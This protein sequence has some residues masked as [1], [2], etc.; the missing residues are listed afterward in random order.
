MRANLQYAEEVATEHVR[1]LL[2]WRIIDGLHQALLMGSHSLITGVIAKETVSAAE[3]DKL[4]TWA[5]VSDAIAR[6]VTLELALRRSRDRAKI[7]TSVRLLAERFCGQGDNERYDPFAMLSAAFVMVDGELGKARVLVSKPPF[8]RRLAAFAQAALITRCVLSTKGDLSKF[9]AWAQSVR[10]AEYC[11]QGYVDLRSEPRWLADFAM[12][13]QLKDEIGGRVLLA[14]ASDEKATD[15]LGLRD[16]L[17]GDAPQ[18]LKKQL[19]LLF[20]LLPGP[21]EGNIDSVTQLQ[22]DVLEQMRK[23]LTDP[24]PLVSSFAPVAN[25]ALLFKLPEDIPGLAADAV[26]RAQYRLDSGGKPETLQSCLVGLATA[27]AVN[28]SHQLADELFI[29]IRSYRRFFRNELDLDAAFRIGMIACSSRANLGDWCKCV[30]ALIGDLG[31]GELTREEA[32]VL[33]PLVI[34]LCDLVPEL[35]AACGQGIAAI[36]AVGFP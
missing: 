36:E 11:M 16:V 8:W 33:H 19:N 28:R 34:N 35:W 27:A 7:G 15:K 3:F 9:I 14:A 5:Q 10:P 23:D 1:K 18:S 6:C 31:F 30:G 4:A 26:R 12:P 25:A 24:S 17:I 20:A 21:I 32:A 2:A 29:V 13:R 22:P